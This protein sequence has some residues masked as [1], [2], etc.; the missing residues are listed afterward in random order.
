MIIF[1]CL[2]IQCA[3]ILECNL[4]VLEGVSVDYN[5]GLGAGISAQVYG[6][7]FEGGEVAV[8]VMRQMME[9]GDILDDPEI[10]YLL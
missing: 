2:V 4:S 10:Q 7:T 8:K 1:C 5:K 9:V 3:C 6:G